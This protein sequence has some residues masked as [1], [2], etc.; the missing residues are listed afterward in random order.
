MTFKDINFKSH[1]SL[2]SCKAS[3]SNVK[4]NLNVMHEVLR[5]VL[6]GLMIQ[7]DTPKYR[8][9]LLQCTAIQFYCQVH[10]VE[11]HKN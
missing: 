5:E 8:Y 4:K 1:C 2:I 3:F 7:P 10:S 11:I 6:E 9:S